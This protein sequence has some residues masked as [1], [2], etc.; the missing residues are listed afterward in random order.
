MLKAKNACSIS[1]TAVGCAVCAVWQRQCV[2]CQGCP[3]TLRRAISV[4]KQSMALFALYLATRN[5]E[6]RKRGE[7]RA[8]ILRGI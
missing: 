3:L 7:E 5:E 8:V 1:I 2:W 6:R 4:C